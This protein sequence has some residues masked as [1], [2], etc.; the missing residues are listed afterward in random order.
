MD[1]IKTQLAAVSKYGFWISTTLVLLCTV[2]I[3]YLSTAALDKE[4]EDQSRKI[5][6]AISTVGGVQQTLDEQPND[7]SH[8]EMDLLIADRQSEVLESWKR[9]YDR[10]Q[11]ILTWPEAEL[12]KD[13]VDEFRKLLPV[14]K[15]VE[16][17]TD[18]SKELE[19]TL[20]SRYQRYIKNILP[21]LASIAD[22]EWTAEFERTAGLEGGMGMGGMGMGGMGM[23][24]PTGTQKEV[25]ITGAEKGPLVQWSNESQNQ[26]L[27]DL[28]PWRG[29]LPTTLEIYYSQ[30]NI[31]ILKQLLG[32]VAELNGEATQ[33]YQAKVH[34][35]KKI[36]IGK[37]VVFSK[38]SISKPGS[39]S[40]GGMGDMSE[41]MDMMDMDMGMGMGMDMDAGDF[42]SM[43]SG[44][45]TTADPAEN[46]YV[47]V[48]LEPITGA[49]LRSAL[50]STQPSNAALAVA[51]RVPVMLSLNM[52]QR[53]I[54]ELIATCG[55]SKLMVEV[56]QV[57][58]LPKSD[59][60]GGMSMGG[61]D[62][63]GGDMGM[64]MG[65]DMG[66]GMGGD[67]GMGMGMGGGMTGAGGGSTGPEEEFPLDMTVEVY[68]IIYIYN[69][70][71]EEK[72]GIE[73]VDE[74]TVIDGSVG[75]TTNPTDTAPATSAPA[76][77]DTAPA[78][79]DPNGAGAPA[80]DPNASAPATTAPDPN[81]NPATP[82]APTAPGTTPAPGSDPNA[83]ASSPPVAATDN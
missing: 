25:D 1:Q 12:G 22:T 18:T 4:N 27:G 40:S 33:P 5:Q 53:A 39:T 37:S 23:S 81:T 44:S 75:S 30:E 56:H 9:L 41:M 3:W 24:G 21:D 61:E 7:L 68:G 51:K 58:M 55:S 70:N 10:Q 36:G 11:N 78:T 38:G 8:Q 83:G 34:E 31:W 52:D 76:N 71:D 17:P 16:F 80:A 64:G 28:F 35:I 42:G 60:G 67:M 13:F 73:L 65:G 66:M 62:S 29:S 69:P 45:G 6:G 77:T 79:T 43:G 47:N 48:A 20:R 74:S 72:L 26:V 49:D 19:T 63:M 15:M 54:P 50:N 2:G 57:R 46:R 14:E 32:I 59:N 82:A